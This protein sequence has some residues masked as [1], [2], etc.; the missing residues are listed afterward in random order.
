MKKRRGKV[1]RDAVSGPGLLMLEGQQY[2][3]SLEDV[4][5]A[6]SRPKPGLIV[7][8]ELDPAGKIRSITP[9]P[10]SQLARELAESTR[11]RDPQGWFRNK[12]NILRL[13]SAGALVC[14]W[15]IQT[16]AYVQVPFP[17][18]LEF[19]F[20]QVLGILHDGRIPELLDGGESPGPGLYGA[21]AVIALVGLFLHDFWRDRR[22]LLGRFLPL[23][24]VIAVGISFRKLAMAQTGK[25]SDAVSLG[26]GTYV[27]VA[28][29]LYFVLI[30]A[31]ELFAP[32]TQDTRT[33]ETPAPTPQHLQSTGRWPHGLPN[34]PPCLKGRGAWPWLWIDRPGPSP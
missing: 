13:A 29:C 11:P 33:T 3:F 9:V 10:D 12:A 20:W 16:S 21:A 14:S 19:T 15:L 5:K 22:A 27:S 32:R 8:V 31:R 18:K 34:W 28:I 1:L 4:W 24:I 30:S 6:D 26:A 17:G 25:S 23:A 2:H 7:D